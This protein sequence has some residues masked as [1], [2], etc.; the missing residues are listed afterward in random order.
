MMP[1]LSL[2]IT[3]KM[4]HIVKEAIP[5]EVQQNGNDSLEW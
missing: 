2:G 5:E 3:T 1:W 4:D